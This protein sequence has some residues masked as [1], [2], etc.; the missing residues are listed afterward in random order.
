[1]EG[2]ITRVLMD[3]TGPS[4]GLIP[5]YRGLKGGAPEVFLV[6]LPSDPPQVAGSRLRQDGCTMANTPGEGHSV[7]LISD[8]PAVFALERS[9]T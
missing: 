9:R 8:G 6:D 5:N 7:A 1:M 2:S 3:G 4:V